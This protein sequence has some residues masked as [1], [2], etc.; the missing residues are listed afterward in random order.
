V[1]LAGLITRCRQLGFEV[2]DFVGGLGSDRIGLIDGLS[3]PLSRSLR[4][5]VVWLA[6]AFVCH[7]WS[8]SR[9]G[10]AGSAGG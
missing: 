1:G 8:W 6:V 7:G 9:T 4:W 3:R 2:D 5:L 10:P